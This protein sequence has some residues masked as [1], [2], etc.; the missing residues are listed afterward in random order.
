LRLHSQA[1]SDGDGPLHARAEFRRHQVREFFDFD[2]AK[3]LLYATLEFVAG[4][5]DIGKG[6]CDVLPDCH[7][8]E[9]GSRLKN[10]LNF[11]A[12]FCEL[13]LLQ[14]RDVLAVNDDPARVGFQEAHDVREGDGFPDAA[15]AQDGE[16]GSLLDRKR[17]A[18]QNRAI[19]KSLVYVDE[20][21][22]RRHGLL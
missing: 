1:P 22:E 8:I 16:S 10:Q 5:P 3:L 11:A 9:K 2:E 19:A 15:G 6:K 12:H 7:R 4:Q 20:F 14:I 13:A 17:H 18:V 21:D